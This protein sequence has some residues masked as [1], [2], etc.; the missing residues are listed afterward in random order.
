MIATAPTPL[1]CCPSPSSLGSDVISIHANEE[2]LEDLLGADE[3]PLELGLVFLPPEIQH[4]YQAHQ[5]VQREALSHSPAHKVGLALGTN[6]RERGNRYRIP[7]PYSRHHMRQSM[8]QTNIS[9]DMKTIMILTWI[10]T[11]T[12][13]Y[14]PVPTYEN[15][16]PTLI[17]FSFYI[18]QCLELPMLCPWISFRMTPNNG[19]T[20]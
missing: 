17:S 14:T 9:R 20:G 12:Y 18:S 7:M 1:S 19:V 8:W 2:A 3:I 11:M 13:I 6:R 10:T 4:L 5:V 16:N 15:S